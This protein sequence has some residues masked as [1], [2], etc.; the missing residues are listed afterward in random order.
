MSEPS[1]LPPEQDA[2]RRLL[3]DARH[4]GPPP[5]D[6]V[7]RLDETLAALTAERSAGLRSDDTAGAASGHEDRSPGRVVDLGSRRRR[8]AGIGLLAAA[9]VVVAGVALGQALP[10][11]SDD[12][13]DSSAG[14]ASD[15]SVA[16]SPEDGGGSSDDAGGSGPD[17]LAGTEPRESKESFP[18]PGLA[19][20]PTLFSDD[21][22]DIVGQ[23]LALRPDVS[24]ARQRLRSL[25]ALRG[26]EGVDPGPSA[27][28]VSAQ[29]DGERGLVVFRRPVGAEQGVEL[30]VC[31]EAVPVRTI[32]LPAP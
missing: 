4:D 25:A 31:G 9:S 29:V 8:V 21:D 16:Q 15:S 26:C 19:D 5:P 18:Q 3:A 7:A 32:T 13:A 28:V 17:N 24:D 2:V 14:S 22:E 12:A 10:R 27:A 23:L 30:Y 20:R 1:G 11:G 6:V